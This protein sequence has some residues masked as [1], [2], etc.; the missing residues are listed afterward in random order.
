MIL[1]YSIL[2]STP[3]VE[4]VL[5]LD[6]TP[7]VESVLCLD[8]TPEVESVLFLKPETVYNILERFST[9]YKKRRKPDS[10]NTIPNKP[11]ILEKWN[12][13]QIYKRTCKYSSEN[14]NS[15]QENI[16]IKIHHY[17]RKNDYYI[18]NV[19]FDDYRDIIDSEQQINE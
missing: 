14:K 4:S 6:S 13:I 2:D 19:L 5:C 9:K 11:S 3:E 16:V 17:P 15:I 8:S 18:L 12:K 1:T 7:E 10:S